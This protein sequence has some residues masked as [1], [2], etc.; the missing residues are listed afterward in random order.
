VT[1][2]SRRTPDRMQH[3]AAA[4]PRVRRGVPRL[5]RAAVWALALIALLVAALLWVRDSS[6]VAVTKVTVTGLTGPEAPRIQNQLED[7]ARDMTTLHVRGDQL[8]S[9]VQPYPVVKDV[10]V[11]S[12][13]PHGLK[14]TVVE[15]T[16]VALISVGGDRTPVGADGKLLRGAAERQ[17]PIVPMRVAPGGTEVVDRT[18]RNAVAALAAAPEALRAR[19]ERASTTREGGLTFKLRDGPDLRFGGADRLA[20]KWA[21]A[22]AILASPSSAGATYLDLRYPERSAAG[23][24]EDPATQHD[25]ESVNAADPTSSTAAPGTTAPVTP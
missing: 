16:P 12:D 18:A 20:A 9:V 13:F 5:P 2:A 21:A 7:A 14:I 11:S 10:R 4:M 15:N 23:G 8:R 1:A 22:A 25:P 3:R 19:V 17:L 6:L 24:M